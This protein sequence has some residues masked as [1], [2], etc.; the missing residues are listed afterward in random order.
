M[1]A[2]EFILP[3]HLATD[4]FK[5]SVAREFGGATVWDAEGFWTDGEKLVLDDVCVF[6]VA[7]PSGSTP[8]R[9]YRL[10]NFAMRQAR[11]GGEKTLFFGLVDCPGMYATGN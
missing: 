4:L 7:L 10:F 5:E 6:R 3:R 11:L 8:A 9:A 1:K 2:Y